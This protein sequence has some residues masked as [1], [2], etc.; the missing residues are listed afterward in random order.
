VVVKD[1]FVELMVAASQ[2]VK[3]V[4]VLFAASSM[5]YVRGL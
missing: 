1:F 4:V 5:S 3:V 2:E